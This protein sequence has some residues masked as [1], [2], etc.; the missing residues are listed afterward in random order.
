MF[1]QHKR[2]YGISERFFESRIPT[3]IIIIFYFHFVPSWV[4]ILT[5]F[6]TM[7]TNNQSIKKQLEN[8]QV[9]NQVVC[10]R[11]SIGSCQ[12][13]WVSMCWLIPIEKSVTKSVS[14]WSPPPQVFFKR[15]RQQ[16]KPALEHKLQAKIALTLNLTIF[17]FEYVPH[18]LQHFNTLLQH[19]CSVL[20]IW[21]VFYNQRCLTQE[22]YKLFI[23][24]KRSI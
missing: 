22:V 1:H 11:G 9:K 12:R 20:R 10:I 18:V 2:L 14:A 13:Y 6:G 8:P 19:I 21:D 23:P 16:L 17:L 24:W 3:L 15:I 4:F 7:E 5:P